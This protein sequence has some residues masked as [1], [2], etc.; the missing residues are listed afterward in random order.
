METPR[1]PFL[2]LN[3]GMCFTP[4][5]PK[6]EMVKIQDIVTSL[7]RTARY[8]GHTSI[9]INT[10]SVAQHCI[11]MA[12]VAP[13]EYKFEALMHDAVEAYMAD[14]PYPVKVL[15]PEI[16]ELE[17]K[18]WQ[19]AIAPKFGL[20]PVMSPEVK[21]LDREMIAYEYEKFASDT[22]KNSGV[23]WDFMH[24]ERKYLN[25]DILRYLKPMEWEDVYNC[26]YELYILMEDYTYDYGYRCNIFQTNLNR[27]RERYFPTK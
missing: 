4:S 19:K 18:I 12:M 1:T 3:S 10:L 14:M 11:A 24:M 27:I 25:T 15:V 5:D 9:K 21:H 16:K 26:F 13:K 20:P 8:L 2:Q 6:P 22:I 7:S 23:E 17:N